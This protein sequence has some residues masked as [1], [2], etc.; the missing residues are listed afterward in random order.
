MINLLLIEPIGRI[1]ACNILAAVN[2]N[3]LTRGLVKAFLENC[4][5][6]FVEAPVKTTEELIGQFE[7]VARGERPIRNG[8]HSQFLFACTKRT[9]AISKTSEVSTV[10][11]VGTLVHYLIE[12]ADGH[13][14]FLSYPDATD[15]MLKDA[16]ER[17][18]DRSDFYRSDA[19]LGGNPDRPFF[20]ITLTEMLSTVRRD[21]SPEDLG[22]AIRDRLGLIHYEDNIP[23]VELRIPG[24]RLRSRKHARPTFADA[25][26][27]RRFRIRPDK[28][29]ARQRSGWGWTVDLLHFANGNTCID[30]IPERVV[31][32]TAFNADTGARFVFAG[33]TKNVRGEKENENDS[34]FVNRVCCNINLSDLKNEL[35]ELF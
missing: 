11:E 8:S 6:A 19:Y 3:V 24:T 16:I 10:I 9:T 23:L 4:L 5:N 12:V 32:R 33:V 22:D 2:E 25:G 7:E 15:S 21:N 20:W 30:G 27:H 34:S 13:A 26:S 1:V 29:S 28:S 35:L 31:E 17:L 18:N 14:S